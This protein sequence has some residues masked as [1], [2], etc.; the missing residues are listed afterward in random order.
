MMT[1]HQIFLKILEENHEK[2]CLIF[3]K[4]YK[5]NLSTWPP[6]EAQVYA[7]HVMKP[8]SIQKQKQELIDFHS[9]L[10]QFQI[11]SCGLLR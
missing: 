6:H 4:Y 11:S 5:E 9:S 10:V 8:I 7:N 3:Q 1:W 2:I